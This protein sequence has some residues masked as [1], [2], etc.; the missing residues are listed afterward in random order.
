MFAYLPRWLLFGLALLS[1]GAL[2]FALVGRKPELPDDCQKAISALDT[3]DYDVA[4]EYFFLCID[5]GE[6]SP[7]GLAD[8]FYNLGNAY[9]A[10]DNHYQAVRDYGEAIALNPDHAWAFNN[11][12]WSYGLL[13]RPDEALRDC[14]EA[15]RLLPDQPEI[16]DSRA[17]ATWLL[18]EPDKARRDLER[19]RELDPSFPTWQERFR[20]FEDMF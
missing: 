9:S 5:T 15:L 14:D 18:G 20:E 17:L 2:L 7:G 11:R 3:S 1:A 4:I 6:L 10:K 8:A 13:R 19:A 16:L 12:C